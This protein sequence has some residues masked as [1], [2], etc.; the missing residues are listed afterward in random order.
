[1]SEE[2]L[3]NIIRQQLDEE[4]DTSSPRQ[5]VFKTAQKG[6]NIFAES[7]GRAV[8]EYLDTIYFER[9]ITYIEDTYEPRIKRLEERVTSLEARVK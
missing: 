4:A 7:I 2:Q 5:R 1:M 8:Y 6:N 9:I 3:V